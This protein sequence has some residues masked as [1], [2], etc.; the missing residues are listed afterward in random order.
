MPVRSPGRTRVASLGP[1]SSSTAGSTCRAPAD[2]G[3]ADGTELYRGPSS[4][5]R[6]PL[7]QD[8]PDGEWLERPVDDSTNGQQGEAELFLPTRRDHRVDEWQL[9]ARRVKMNA[10]LL[11]CIM[12]HEVTHCCHR[13]WL[14]SATSTA[15][16]KASIEPSHAAISRK[17]ASASGASWK[18]ARRSSGSS[19]HS[20]REAGRS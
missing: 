17:N 19:H 16:F 3:S 5:G 20:G 18:R 9:A 1:S 14:S 8:Q 7:R 6:E 10:T 15:E 12:P 11:V 2:S 13:E 4:R